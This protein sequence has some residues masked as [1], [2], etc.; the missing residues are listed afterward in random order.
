[1]PCCCR[2]NGSNWPGSVPRMAWRWRKKRT[3]RW[4]RESGQAFRVFSGALLRSQGAKSDSVSIKWNETGTYEIKIDAP[5]TSVRRGLAYWIWVFFAIMP[6]VSKSRA[7]CLGPPY[8][9]NEPQN[10]LCEM[11]PSI[12]ICYAYSGGRGGVPAQKFGLFVTAGGRTCG[13]VGRSIACPHST[14]HTHT[15]QKQKSNNKRCSDSDYNRS[16]AR[17]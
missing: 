9:P 14:S 4:V 5:S 12:E 3:G 11:A 1:M 13:K 2:G 15:T 10:F 16:H 8:P 7:F 17:S 6:S